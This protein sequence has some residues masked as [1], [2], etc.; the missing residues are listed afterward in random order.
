M[1]SKLEKITTVSV[2]SVVAAMVAFGGAVL[3]SDEPELEDLDLEVKEGRLLSVVV[4]VG[5]AYS[6]VMEFRPDDVVLAGVRVVVFVMEDWALAIE[7]VEDEV[8]DFSEPQVS[9]SELSGGIPRCTVIIPSFSSCGVGSS[10]LELSDS[11]DPLAVSKGVSAVALTTSSGRSFV[12][13]NRDPMELLLL[14]Y[15]VFTQFFRHCLYYAKCC[16]L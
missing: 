12:E 3:R 13:F 1:T 5:G 4:H 6:F 10:D 7:A 8:I 11:S 16:F 14:C 2:F 9:S 15:R